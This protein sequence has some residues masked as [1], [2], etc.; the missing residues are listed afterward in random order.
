M[1]FAT[2]NVKNLYPSREVTPELTQLFEDKLNWLAQ[3]IARLDADYIVLQEVGSLPALEEVV[4]RSG[5]AYQVFMATPSKRGIANAM[6]YKDT[7]T[8]CESLLMRDLPFPV[9][10]VGEV[11]AIGKHLSVNRSFVYARSIFTG[12][13]LHIFGIHLKSGFGM[14]ILDGEVEVPYT[15]HFGGGEATIRALVNRLGEAQA[16]RKKID[17]IVAEDP[18]AQVIVAGDFNDRGPAISCIQGSWELLEVPGY[19][20]RA[21]NYTEP[22]DRYTFLSNNRN[23][24]QLDHVLVTRNLYADIE[25]V[26]IYNKELRNHVD[27]EILM[28]PTVDSDHAPVEVVFRDEAN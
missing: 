8:Q 16:L 10:Q 9:F 2:F 6:L 28:L 5:I 11:D 7:T 27:L 12:K 22:S 1:K 26:T 13:A 15:T 20:E 18:H 3:R 14:P 17:E 19:L 24:E 21:T 4:K 23:Q 25:Q